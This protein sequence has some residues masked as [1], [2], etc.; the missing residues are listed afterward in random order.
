MHVCPTN[1]KQLILGETK[2]WMHHDILAEPSET[3]WS[4]DWDL[5][6]LSLGLKPWDQLFKVSVSVSILEIKVMSLSLKIWDQREKSQ[7]QS[8]TLIPSTKSLGLSLQ[9]EILVS[10][11]HIIF[12]RF[13]ID[14]Q[15][16]EFLISWKYQTFD[17]IWAHKLG[18]FWFLIS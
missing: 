16:H 5:G 14:L 15:P 17:Q 10:H 12:Q 3:L 18:Y 6:G 13:I 4:R 1:P 2:E 7:S 8:Q 11:T 9:K